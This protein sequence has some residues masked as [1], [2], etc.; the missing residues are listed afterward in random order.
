MSPGQ[1]LTANSVG[2]SPSAHLLRYTAG[3]DAPAT[4]LPYNGDHSP[5]PE[6]NTPC[7]RTQTLLSEWPTLTEVWSS[8]CFAR[9]PWPCPGCPALLAAC[10][11]QGNLYSCIG[12]AKVLDCETGVQSDDGFGS[13]TYPSSQPG[14]LRHR[15]NAY[16]KSNHITPSEAL[17][18]KEVLDPLPKTGEP[19]HTA[20]TFLTRSDWKHK[21]QLH[22]C[23]GQCH[24][25]GSCRACF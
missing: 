19:P 9:S 23:V 18:S 2:M 14:Y 21:R 12:L 25:K 11:P 7:D 1:L 5:I 10:L 3:R 6:G 22:V 4:P 16:H 13:P 17:F 24:Q 15:P 8:K 20:Q